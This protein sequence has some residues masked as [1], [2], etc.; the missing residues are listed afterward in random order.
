MA[1]P[2]TASTVTVTI[3]GYTIPGI[4]GQSVIVP[5]ILVS[6]QLIQWLTSIGS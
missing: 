3:G 6:A 4:P 2:F 1:G 5:G